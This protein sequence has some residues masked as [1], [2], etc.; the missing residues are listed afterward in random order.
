MKT[1]DRERPR[2]AVQKRHAKKVKRKAA[3]WW[4]HGNKK[5]KQWDKQRNIKRKRKREREMFKE[6]SKSRATE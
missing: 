4:K 2:D 1:I 5:Q 6:A 3:N